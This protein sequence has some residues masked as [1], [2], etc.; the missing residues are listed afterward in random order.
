MK[1]TKLLS[2]VVLIVFSIFA[3]YCLLMSIILSIDG[4]SNDFGIE[5]KYILLSIFLVIVNFFLFRK[6]I[7][8][9]SN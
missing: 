5:N 9:N 7:K 3:M 6:A 1:N 8:I 4:V 2:V